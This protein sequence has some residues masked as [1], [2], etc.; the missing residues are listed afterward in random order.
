[1]PLTIHE[2][3]ARVPA[4]I[5]VPRLTA[6]ARTVCESLSKDFALTRPRVSI[7]GLNPHAGEFGTIGTEERDVIMPAIDRLRDE[8]F[9]VRG[10]FSA[11]TLFHAEARESYDAV[12]TMYHDQALIPIKTLAF[13]T[14]VNTTI[15]LPFVRTSP[16]H[17]TAFGLAGKGEARAQSLIAAIQLASRMV[18][19]RSARHGRAR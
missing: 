3:I 18:R 17:G 10:P 15:G 13:D 12:V 6:V 7:T 2:P 4:M 1:V 9:D 14:G 8:G 16:D 5:T 11:D 19:N